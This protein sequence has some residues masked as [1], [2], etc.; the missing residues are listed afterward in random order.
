VEKSCRIAER[1]D[2]DI[3]RRALA[4]ERRQRRRHHHR[5]DILRIQSGLAGLDAESIEHRLQTLCREA[6]PLQLVAGA[7]QSDDE[8]VAD[9]L[10]FADAFDGHDVL[11]AR[12]DGMGRPRNDY[13]HGEQR[14][15]G[16]QSPPFQPF[17][18]LG[19]PHRLSSILVGNL[20]E[21]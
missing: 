19:G 20:R 16:R 6:T 15:D 4:G 18:T 10:V 2:V 21:R 12:G 8:A 9:E 14:D 5:R 17:K 3:D 1:R 11:D 7:V 13:R